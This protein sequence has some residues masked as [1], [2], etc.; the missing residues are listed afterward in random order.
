MRSNLSKWMKRVQATQADEISCSQCLDQVSQYVDLELSNADEAAVRMPQVRQ[1]LEQCKVCSEEYQLL[2]ELASLER[3]GGLPTH[4]DLI[5][6][7]K[8]RP[9]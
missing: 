4:A 5:E 9:K 2:R 3:Q 1:H 7:L 6:R 8:H